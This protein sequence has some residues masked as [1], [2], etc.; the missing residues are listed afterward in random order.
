LNIPYRGNTTLA[1]LA[2]VNSFTTADSRIDDGN[3]PQIF[4]TPESVSVS[5]CDVVQD[6]VDTAMLK[7]LLRERHYRLANVAELLVLGSRHPNFL[8]GRDAISAAQYLETGTGLHLYPL[9]RPSRSGQA[10][11]LQQF[12][13]RW[14]RGSHIVVA[15]L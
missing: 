6:N 8:R 4:S 15:R 3:F 14:S 7:I 1:A 5:V 13:G 11:L 12:D 9:I 10:A 2:A